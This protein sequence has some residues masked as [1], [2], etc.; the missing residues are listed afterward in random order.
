MVFGGQ[1]VLIYGEPRLTRDIDIT[2]GIEPHQAKPVLQ[3]IE[4]LELKIRIDNV[5]EFLA[6]TFVLPVLDPD[7]KFLIDF[8]FSLTEFERR[9]I[10]RNRIVEIDGVPVRYIS[11][12]DL[13]ITKIIAGR[14]RDLED[15]KGVLLKNPNFDRAFVVRA[16]QEFD[17]DLD[18]NFSAVFD[19]LQRQIAQ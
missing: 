16:L 8:V 15:A 2:L 11:L 14:P 5:E 19:D 1:A 7:S 4:E 18:C 9:A 10:G 3:L 17:R 12:E 13:I 6:Q